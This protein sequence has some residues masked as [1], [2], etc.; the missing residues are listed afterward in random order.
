[1]T[2]YIKV[3]LSTNNYCETKLQEIISALSTLKLQRPRIRG[4]WE[5]E[6]I[7]LFRAIEGAH[8]LRACEVLGIPPILDALDHETFIEDVEDLDYVVED[9]E[10]YVHEI[11]NCHNYAVDF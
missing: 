5:G 6:N 8:L 4:Y 1:M 2:T 11:G 9:Q 3:V 7:E 10:L